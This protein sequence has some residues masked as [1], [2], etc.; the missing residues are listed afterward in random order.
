MDTAAVRAR[1]KVR[2]EAAKERDFRVQ[3][4]AFGL[5]HELHR[6]G[7]DVLG[8]TLIGDSPEDRRKRLAVVS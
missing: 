6:R 8:V 1:I 5:A 3:H 4:E 7:Y 2:I